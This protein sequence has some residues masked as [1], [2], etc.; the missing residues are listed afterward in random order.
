MAVQIYQALNQALKQ[1]MGTEAINVID[2]QGIASAGSK[3]FANE[4]TVDS[5]WNAFVDIVGRVVAAIR[6]YYGKE[7][8]VGREITEWGAIME[9]IN[10][11]IEDVEEN[12]SYVDMDEIVDPMNVK[13]SITP[14]VSYYKSFAVWERDQYQPLVQM[15]TAFNGPAQMDIFL[16]GL[17]MAMSNARELENDRIN[18]TAINAR[19]AATLYAASQGNGALTVVDLLT[20]YNNMFQ[21]NLTAAQCIYDKDWLAYASRQIKLWS[22]RMSGYSTLFNNQGQQRH[23]PKDL[24]VLEVLSDFSSASEFYLR[25]NTF[26][27]ELVRMPMYTDV[28]YWQG[29]GESYD[30]ADTS[31]ISITIAPNITITRNNIVGFLRDVDAV[32]T[33]MSLRK[34]LSQV[35]LKKEVNNYFQKAEEGLYYDTSENGVVFVLGESDLNGSTNKSITTQNADLKIKKASNTTTIKA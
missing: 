31:A 15:R 25:S 27:E 19:M 21:K 24:Q 8:F 26:H 4:A 23:T 30:F 5:V 1:G 34:T 20:P 3:I 13:G 29:T 2:A 33:M 18:A 28:P 6:P 10:Y 11:T 16:S 22:D 32:A 14:S 17:F 35:N 9:K 12:T 7:R